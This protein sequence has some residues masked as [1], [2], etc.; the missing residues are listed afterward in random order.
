MHAVAV[1]QARPGGGQPA[2]P[3]IAAAR[4]EIEALLVAL[5]VKHAQFHPLRMGGKS[6]KFTPLPS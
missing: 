2:V 6:A 3:D 5:L 1:A 4:G